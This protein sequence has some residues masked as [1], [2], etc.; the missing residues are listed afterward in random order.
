MSGLYDLTRYPFLYITEMGPELEMDPEAFFRG[1]HIDE[2]FKNFVRS[3][4][5]KKEAPVEE[6]GNELECGLILL[7]ILIA[8]R[9]L[10]DRRFSNAISL[11][12]SK[13]AGRLLPEDA[14]R[15][16]QFPVY[17]AKKIGIDARYVSD[18]PAKLPV[19]EKSARGKRGKLEGRHMLFDYCI[20]L[21]D[22]L[23]ITAP[24]LAQDPRYHISNKPVRGG[25]VYLSKDDFLRVVEEGVASFINSLLES[26]ELAKFEKEGFVKLVTDLASQVL[27]ELNWFKKESALEAEQIGKFIVEAAPPCIAKILDNISSGGNPSHDER[28]TLAA[29]LVNIGLGVDEILELFRNTADFNERIA[30]YQIEHIA[31]LRGSGKKYLPSSCATLKSKGICPLSDQCK[32]GK[33]PLSVYKYNVRALMK[34]GAR[35]GRRPRGSPPSGPPAGSQ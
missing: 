18:N 13:T 21:T 10:G 2:M 9:A 20:R 25:W 24:R 22:Y 28:F 31:G 4:A 34:S 17:V 23:R 12:Y 35:E 6:C 16:P 26:D 32:G 1:A 27:Q 5:E 3:I 30:R 7:G 14:S 29:F 19:V 8:A 15:D 33:N 11:S